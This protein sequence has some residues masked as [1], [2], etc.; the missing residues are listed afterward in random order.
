MT[1]SSRPGIR[2]VVTSA[3]TAIAEAHRVLARMFEKDETVDRKEWRDS[4][5]EREAE[6]WS[7]YR[8]HLVVA[9]LEGTVVGMASGTYLGNVNTGVI[10]YVAVDTSARGL[11]L[12]PRLRAKLRTLFRRDAR[13][14]CKGALDAVI[15][16]VRRD[17]PWLRSLVRRDRVL[18]LDFHYMQPS[19]RDGDAP[20]SLVLY[21]EPQA[22]VMRRV[23]TALLRKLLFTTWR[24]VYRISRPMAHRTFRQMI[25]QL[26]GHRSIGRLTPQRLARLAGDRPT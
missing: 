15:G 18:A 5:R 17:N 1:L 23:P 26:D 19:L 13:Q 6:V 21:Y 2:E 7:D 4:L 25:A 12:G 10:G 22:R 24:R 20:V 8:W 9:E 14:I 11:G 3:D 16:E